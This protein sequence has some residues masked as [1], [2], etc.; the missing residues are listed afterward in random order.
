MM[1]RHKTDVSW[2][3]VRH[4]ITHCGAMECNGE[5]TLL[6]ISDNQS[7][8]VANTLVAQ[9]GQQ[10]YQW[11]CDLFPLCRSLTGAGVRKT[12]DYIRTILPDLQLRSVPSGTPAFDC[13]FGWVAELD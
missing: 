8:D 11:A 12:L 13:I 5:E 6:I 2:I 10:T 4:L 7:S 9:Y 3:A 1:A